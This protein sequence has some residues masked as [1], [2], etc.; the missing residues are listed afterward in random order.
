MAIVVH[1]GRVT[2]REYRTPVN[3]FAADDGFVIA[4][5]YGADRDWVRNVR[6]AGG[7]TLERRGRRVALA[8][9][10]LRRGP[11]AQALVPAPIRPILRLL[12]VTEILTLSPVEEGTPG[13]T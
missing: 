9:P 2:G 1:R 13:P 4:L 8:D 6:G 11:E 10:Q 7:C 3:A 12:R 5:T